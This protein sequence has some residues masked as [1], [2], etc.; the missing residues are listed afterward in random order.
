MNNKQKIE[1]AMLLIGDVQKDYLE[2][3]DRTGMYILKK[4]IDAHLELGFAKDRL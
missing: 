2:S 3:M 1:K 4:L